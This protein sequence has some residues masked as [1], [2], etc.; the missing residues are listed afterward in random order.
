MKLTNFSITNF[1]SITKAH[2]VLTGKN[3]ILLGKNNEGKSNILKA[4]Q[5]AM[6]IL[7]NYTSRKIR[8]YSDNYTYNW[9]R[10]FPIHLQEKKYKQTKKETIFR[11]EFELSEM[12]LQ[13]FKS[14]LN[15][16]LNGFL[17]LEIK[18]GSENEPN[19]SII[20]SGKRNER[21]IDKKINEILSFLSGKIYFNYI[22][23]VRT[24]QHIIENIDQMLYE[25]L[26][27]LEND[28]NYINALETI[29]NLRK[30]ILEKLASELQEPLREFLPSIRS[31]SI[32]ANEINRRLSS[33]RNLSIIIDDGH[34]TLLEYKGDGIKSLVAL[35]LL[36]NLKSNCDTSIIAIEEPESHLHPGAI[37]QLNEIIRTIDDQNQ[38]IITT[39]NPLFVNRDNIKSNIIINNGKATQAKNISEIREILGIKASDNLINANFVLLVE[40]KEDVI[41]LNKILPNLSSIISKAIKDKILIIES[42]GGAGNLSYKLSHLKASLCNTHVLLDNDK[43]GKNAFY[44]ARKD[45]NILDNEITFTIC[46]GRKPESEFEDCI[47][48]DIYK[49]AIL[50]EFGVDIEKSSFRGEN[51]WSVR[52][53]K[54]FEEHGKITE[55]DK[56]KYCVA[57][58]ILNS[59]SKNYLH[60]HNGK[61]IISLKET[62][63][64]KIISM[65]L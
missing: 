36:K 27:I 62:L 24:E 20:K 14:N 18:I 64:K 54:T 39:H 32:E 11:L 48:E 31:V 15:I 19:V 9:N 30:P 29:N 37:H 50:E 17:S 57:N 65:K 45:G 53:T 26:R 40:G 4:L 21:T 16:N 33:I 6:E 58:A 23:A 61:S 38:L 60:E 63:E 59:T 22:P 46:K 3:T 44:T 35:G 55:L 41:S 12:E 28:Q 34:P 8:R 10:D 56:I 25:N 13:A 43:A 7:K 52:I 51:K 2:K 5:I 49:N 47:N 42:L 1:R